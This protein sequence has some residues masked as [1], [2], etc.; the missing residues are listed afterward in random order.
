MTVAEVAALVGLTPNSV[1][2]RIESGELPSIRLGS[3]PKAPIRIDPAD[4]QTWLAEH[5]AVGAA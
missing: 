1:Y 4:L 5:Y 2:K 3:G